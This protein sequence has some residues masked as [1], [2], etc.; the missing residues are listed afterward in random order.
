MP[1]LLSNHPDLRSRLASW[2][3]DDASLTEL[4][5]LLRSDSIATR[6]AAAREAAGRKSAALALI[7][8]LEW[9]PPR[10]KG[11]R[12]EI[13]RHNKAV[14]ELE[15]ACG[16]ALAK[17]GGPAVQIFVAVLDCPDKSL[18]KKG[19]YLRA[20]RD[21][22]A[23]GSLQ[24]CLTSA[25]PVVKLCAAQALGSIAPPDAV[26][27][28]AA[29]MRDDSADV[30]HAAAEALRLIG[31]RPALQALVD[32]LQDP[33]EETRRAA[34]EL[35]AVKD[36]Q[37][38]PFLIENLSSS[39]ALVVEQTA[40]ALVRVRDAAA[41][42]ALLR[43]LVSPWPAAAGAALKALKAINPEWMASPETRAA[44]PYF[45]SSLRSPDAGT[46]CN[47][48]SVLAALAPPS[49]SAPLLEALKQEPDPSVRAELAKAIAAIGDQASADPLLAAVAAETDDG[50]RVEIV[51]AVGALA[52][53]D[54]VESLAALIEPEDRPSRRLVDAVVNALART[55]DL[56]AVPVLIDVL[57][58]DRFNVPS[59]QLAAEAL[60]KIGGAQ[61]VTA[62][63]AV[64][65]SHWSDGTRASGFVA[66][67]AQQALRQQHLQER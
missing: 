57:T 59:A 27:H 48:A 35:S 10:P 19:V 61:A 62:L 33:R 44:L 13:M 8:C 47:A 2:E 52:H 38:G 7:E 51:N 28:L 36:P 46:R 1:Q 5:S 26:P 30:R 65:E 22:S 14:A 41:V 34:Q 3:T 31:G 25:N 63:K 16:A 55:E 20:V 54:F 4:A 67:A 58:A 15:Q 21:V 43:V 6:T 32:A 66:R 29:A 40:L 9:A 37:A 60:G 56:R 50:A 42:P 45:L 24:E 18:A 39:A 11:G 49:A 17:V 12:L 53:A 23:V 64:Q